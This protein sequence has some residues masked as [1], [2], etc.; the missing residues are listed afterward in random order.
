VIIYNN[1]D[2]DYFI[3]IDKPITIR[4]NHLFLEQKGGDEGVINIIDGSIILEDCDIK[5]MNHGIIFDSEG[6]CVLSQCKLH[7]GSGTAIEIDRGNI[8]I[9]NC[10]FYNMGK[11]DK[12][13]KPS[14][15]TIT[16]DKSDKTKEPNIKLKDNIFHDNMGKNEQI[17][18]H[19]EETTIQQY[20]F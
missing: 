16:I 5:I 8:L 9:E 19:W 1:E 2:D 11:G 18:D 4:L 7:D 3:S 6:Y 14:W 13:L 15:G 12:I 10:E 17:I 20:Y